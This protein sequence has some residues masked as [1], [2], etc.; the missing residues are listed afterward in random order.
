[1]SHSIKKKRQ[2]IIFFRLEL[3]FSRFFKGH[4]LCKFFKFQTVDELTDQCGQH[5]LIFTRNRYGTVVA[6]P[7]P[8]EIRLIWR[9]YRV[10]RCARTFI[11]IRFSPSNTLT[12][13]FVYTSRISDF[14]YFFIV[15]HTMHTLYTYVWVWFFVRREWRNVLLIGQRSHWRA[16]TWNVK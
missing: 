11:A 6:R 1:M 13:S 16:G 4:I 3:I 14:N 12:M 8:L 10:Q 9:F 2:R 5:Y 15:I 7:T